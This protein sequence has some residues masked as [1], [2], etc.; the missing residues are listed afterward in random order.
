M[1]YKNI[2]FDVDGTLLDSYTPY[3]N[4]LEK[5]VYKFTGNI[6]DDKTK[7]KLFH[8]TNDEIM[9]Y[10]GVNPNEYEDFIEYN[11]SCL[12]VNEVYLYEGIEE[13]II[14]LH[15]RGYFLGINTSRNI[16]EVY[17]VPCLVKILKY[18]D[19][20]MTCD[21]VKNPKPDKESLIKIINDNKLDIGKT[22]KN[23]D[24]INDSKCAINS[25]CKFGLASWGARANSIYCDYY[26][27]DVK[28]NNKNI[29]KKKKN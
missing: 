22:I 7:D 29:K 18:F 5:A 6:L 12:N 3:M 13:L 4:A 1:E 20:I 8:M 16:D 9:K 14:Y 2:I 17:E 23:D 25:L 19:Y 11:D 24:R 15:N 27:N 28:N 26:L 10:V 21:K